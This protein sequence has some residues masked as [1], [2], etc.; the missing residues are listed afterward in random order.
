MLRAVL[1]CTV[2]YLFYSTVSPGWWF[3]P[4]PGPGPA[5][6]HMLAPTPISPDQR[7]CPQHAAR[8]QHAPLTRELL[9]PWPQTPHAVQ[10]Y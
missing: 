6:P 4:R 5:S 3:V 8:T 10:Q 2:L 7:L 9:L 1:Y